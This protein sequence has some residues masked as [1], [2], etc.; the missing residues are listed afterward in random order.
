MSRAVKAAYL[1]KPPEPRY[2]KFWDVRLVLKTMKL[3]G[4]NAKLS[5]KYLGFK[6]LVL[7]LLVTGQR[8]QVAL[9]LS[10]DRMTEYDDGSVGFIL[11]KPMKTAK[12]GERLLELKLLPYDTVSKLCVVRTLREY[13]S[14]TKDLRLSKDLF[15]SYVKKHKGVSKGTIARWITH[16]LR[17]SGVNVTKY[18]PHSLRGAG[19]SAGAKMGVNMDI[20][21]KYGSWRRAATMA[22]H[23]QKPVEVDPD[24]DLGRCLLDSINE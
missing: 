5:L 2:S 9:A 11:T 13:L 10:I 14:R 7:M 18:G 6:L 17:V 22:R 20:L 21:L 19:V 4:R 23:Y 8:S 3:W 12:T 24:Q 16:V 1:R 15:V